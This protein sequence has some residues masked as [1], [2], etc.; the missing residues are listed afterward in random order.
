MNKINVA[1]IGPCP[2]PIGGVSV[3][4]QRL[5]SLLEINGISVV[6]ID[7]APIT[8]I[9]V[10]NLRSLNIFKYFK[11]L[12][13]ADIVHIHSSINIL[14]IVNILTCLLLS[15]RIVLTLHSWRVDSKI[16]KKIQVFLF[17]KLETVICVNESIRKDISIDNSVVLPAFLPADMSAEKEL[18]VEVSDWINARKKKSSLVISSNAYRLD[19]F[20]G[21][22]LYGLDMAISLIDY[23]VNIEKINISLVFIVSSLRKNDIEF[24]KYIKEINERGIHSNVL[25]VHKKNL[26]FVKLIEVSDLTL[27]A[28]NTDG[29]ALSIRESLFLN[30]PIIASN[31]TSR[32][33]GTIVFDSRSQD[34][35][36]AKVLH[37]LKN[38]NNKEALINTNLDF[39]SKYKTIYKITDIK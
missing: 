6:K 27:R 26:S 3:H 34:D 19:K 25:L 5:S 16:L 32:P 33:T 20:E 18:E 35:L 7:E 30:T 9:G 23:L 29:D 4:I 37:E 17:S 12:K 13:R 39:F 22:D 2:P 1:I 31:A 8:K 14:R 28:T 21:V 36:N 11:I 15:K 24:E 10:Y 38:L